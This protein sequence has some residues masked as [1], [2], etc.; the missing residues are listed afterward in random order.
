[1][2]AVGE[3]VIRSGGE[4]HGWT[5]QQGEREKEYSR[6][7]GRIEHVEKKCCMYKCRGKIAET[8]RSK[9]RR[10]FDVE[11][12][13]WRVPF[14]PLSDERQSAKWIFLVSTSAHLCHECFRGPRH[15][16][17]FDLRVLN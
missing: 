13:V 5:S 11:E 9:E 6:D 16:F 14:S 12:E 4:L 10:E 3:V 8:A 7:L 15:S 17:H 2:R 1:M